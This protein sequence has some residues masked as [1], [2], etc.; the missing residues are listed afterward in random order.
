MCNI[1]FK[2]ENPESNSQTAI[3]NHMEF[4]N[5]QI[6]NLNLTNRNNKPTK[7]QIKISNVQI[8]N[9]KPQNATIQKTQNHR[10]KALNQSKSPIFRNSKPKTKRL[11]FK[12]FKIIIQ[13]LQTTIFPKPQQMN[14]KVQLSLTYMPNFFFLQLRLQNPKSRVFFF[15]IRTQTYSNASLPLPVLHLG[16]ELW[17]SLKGRCLTKS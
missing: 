5:F 1:Q 7:H 8:Q 10:S 11:P 16:I 14:F 12:K 2:T 6:S 17:L 15:K 9:S 4:L 13:S 3:V